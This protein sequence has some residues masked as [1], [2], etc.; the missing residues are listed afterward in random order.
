[1]PQSIDIPKYH[2]DNSIKRYV[3]DEDYTYHSDRYDKDVILRKGYTSD[4]ATGAFDIVSA[5]WWIHDKLCEDMAWSD[6]TP[7]TRWQGSRVCSDIL[8]AEGR[9][10]RQFYWRYATMA[11]KWW[12]NLTG[13]D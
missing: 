4:G 12:A 11:P 9:W 2:Y 8:K 7:C 1:M 10:A 6:G 3:L 13:R 5:A